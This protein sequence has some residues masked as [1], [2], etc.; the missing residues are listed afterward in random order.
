[1]RIAIVTEFFPKSEK[2]EIRGGVEARAFHVAKQLAKT[3]DVTVITTREHGTRKKDEFLGFE[4]LRL[5]RE[6]RYSQ[7]GSLIERLSFVM[8]GGKITGKF[9]VVDGYNFVS[10]PVAW[11]IAQRN[12]VPAIATYH[13]VWLG[14]WIENIGVGGVLGELL[15]RYV[16]GRNWDK[17]IAVSRFT[18]EKLRERK[19]PGERIEVIPNGIEIRE[20]QKTRVE[21]YSPPTICC[22]SRLVEYKHVDDL[23]KAIAIV[24]RDIPDIACKIIGGGPEEKHLKSLA[25]RLGLQKNVE[26]LGFV[27]EHK[28]VVKILKASHAFCLPSVVEGFGMVLLEAMASQVPYVASEIEP[29]VEATDRKG[30]LFFKPR[31]CR[32]LADKLLQILKDRNAYKKCVKEGSQHVQ[33]YAWGSIVEKIEEVYESCQR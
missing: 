19:I 5:G 27:E 24:K 25:I 14:K 23:L 26:F 15:E 6:R 22:I 16:L 30:G 3:H 18:G 21:K 28:E 20:Y 11:E 8:E 4:V 2:V 29:L 7:K 33:N 10:Y 12:K 31:D 17:F 1:M 13:E 9:D 32:D